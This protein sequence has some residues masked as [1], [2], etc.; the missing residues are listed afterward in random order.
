[1]GRN[2]GPEHVG[3]YPLKL[4]HYRP[5]VHGPFR[6]FNARYVLNR[7]GVARR[8]L[9]ATDPA[10]P[11]GYEEHLVVGQSSLTDLLN[12]P[13]GVEATVIDIDHRFPLDEYPEVSR[14]IER[15]VIRADWNRHCIGR[16]GLVVAL[17]RVHRRGL[18]VVILPERVNSLRP[19]LRKD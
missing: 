12:S 7:L 1:M 4:K 3:V 6:D 13:V 11:F 5:Y 2:T 10:Y 8:V 18:V 17:W 9:E 15:Q 19:I 14:L 16:S